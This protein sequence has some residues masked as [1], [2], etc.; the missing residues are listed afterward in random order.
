MYDY[1][2]GNKLNYFTDRDDTIFYWFEGPAWT[3]TRY[4]KFYPATWTKHLHG[5]APGGTYYGSYRLIL[6]DG[7]RYTYRVY[8]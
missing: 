4:A 1:I 8:L 5:N 7:S 3:G 2:K 6:P